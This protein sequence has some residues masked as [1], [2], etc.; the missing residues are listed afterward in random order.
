M[1]T[2]RTTASTAE[3]EAARE[4]WEA[5]EEAPEAFDR[6]RMSPDGRDVAV[7]R[8]PNDWRVS[9]GGHYRDL[10]VADWLPLIVA[11]PAGP[12]ADGGE[13]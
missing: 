1:I 8:G 3:F 12:V 2:D 9:N 7:R 5:A 4:R 13:S 11:S 6:A 10:H